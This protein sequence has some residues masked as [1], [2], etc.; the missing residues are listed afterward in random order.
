MSSA[1]AP[2]KPF[3]PG[4]PIAEGD[5]IAGKY[6]VES[7]V[8]IGGMGVVV[9]ATHLALGQIVAI[10][11]L[12][13]LEASEDS[14]AA[15]PRFLREARAAAGL[16]SEHVVRI[17]DVDT[18]PSGLP[19]MVMELLSG[20]DLRRVIKL[21]GPLPIEQAVD[22]V[23]QAADAIGE[24]HSAGIVH[25]DLKPSNLFLT[26][27]TDGRPWVKV[28]DF[29]ISK[30]S[31]DP[32]TDTALTV[33]RAMIGSP[34]YMS[35]EQV[36]DAKSVDGRSDIWSLGVIL[37]ELLSGKPA[38]RGESLPAICAAI[39]ADQPESLGAARP[40]L[41]PEFLLVAARCLQ[42]DPGRRHQSVDELCA[43]LQP[44]QGRH[45]PA[46]PVAS[47]APPLAIASA[48][49]PPAS[50]RAALGSSET[51]DVAD[52]LLSSGASQPIS[53]RVDGPFE[54]SDPDAPTVLRV[55]AS[56][57]HAPS[58]APFSKTRSVAGRRSRL[59]LVLGATAVVLLGALAIGVSTLA[60]ARKGT[61]VDPAPPATAFSLVIES[62]PPAAEV[63]EADRVL[64]KTP[65]SIDVERSSVGA[66]PRE[67]SL[68][69]EGHQPY[70]IQ[71]GDS[72]VDV[73]VRA[74]LVA[75][76]GAA[77]AA[78][79]PAPAA[80]SAAAPGRSRPTP[81]KPAPKKPEPTPKPKTDIRLSR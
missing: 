36:R 60:T 35:P 49:P 73:K 61:A 69:L 17:F 47:G 3:P 30:A 23:L 41:P 28:L 18:L 81:A 5:V 50:G 22:F 55:A 53:V 20:Q 24:A 77:V 64:G 68:K 19:Y 76:V 65:L 8:A 10:K 80:S 38:F 74:P 72:A 51:I 46:R 12:L 15:I 39:A 34:M 75:V 43:A 48:Q 16:K 54:R 1:A 7:M 59:P 42:K 29:G 40:D 44:F 79:A 27:R 31:H 37:H 4:M 21:G 2:K 11:V 70:R 45:A 14:T 58:D 63:I 71:Q 57:P 9:S 26:Q 6:R 78:E 66:G 13:P 32:L 25:R 67:F 52:S 62:V 33:T 56:A